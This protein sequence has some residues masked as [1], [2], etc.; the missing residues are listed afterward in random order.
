MRSG[1]GVALR[2]VVLLAAPV[3]LLA[4]CGVG[5]VGPQVRSLTG[6]TMGTSFRVA[7][8]AP[9]ELGDDEVRAAVEAELV[10]I[11]ARASTWDEASELS[12]FN[13]HGSTGPFEVSPELATQVEQALELARATGGA[14][15]PTVMPLVRLYG[16]AAEVA[17]GPPD[18]DAVA[19]L[20]VFVGYEHVRVDGTRL[21]K[22]DPRVELDLSAIAKG[23]GV[24]RL[25]AVLDGLGA[26]AWLV[27]IG[28]EVRAR[29]RK[30]D[31]SPWIVG[32]ELPREGRPPG[33]EL[34]R[35]LA[36]EGAALATSGDYRLFREVEGR[37]VH[38]VVDPRTGL[39]ATHDLAEVTVLAPTCARADALAT[40]LLVLGADEG[41]ALVERL[42]D[43]EALFVRRDGRG[44]FATT[45]SA[46][47][48]AL[49]LDG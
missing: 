8:V 4:G 24:D 6:G 21:I 42:P 44:G 11:S 32:V 15:D 3:L 26:T 46:G 20:R 9:A 18:P 33:S 12:R 27:E 48:S 7:Y 28:G 40:A 36:L 23:D 39:N 17:P 22:D 16:F 19:E 1:L 10:A 49:S 43:V 2:C 14:F 25:G 5:A 45:Q 34:V 30:P 37:R 31:G 47:L 41:L 38:H 13:R 29:G 35:R